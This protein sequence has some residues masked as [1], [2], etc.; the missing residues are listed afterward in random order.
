M[1]MKNFDIMKISKQRKLTN[2]GA[3]PKLKQFATKVDRGG[4]KDSIE[5]LL[6]DV[7]NQIESFV[8]P[9]VQL[10]E[11]GAYGHMNHPFDTDINLTFGQLKDIV[12]KALD[13]K[14][15]VTKEK[16]DGQALAVSWKNGRGR[17]RL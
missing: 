8:L 2:I 1:R 11:G 6:A 17:W 3:Y 7:D 5:E 14:L 9:N 12:S 16:T 15:D 4:L 13:G 10:H